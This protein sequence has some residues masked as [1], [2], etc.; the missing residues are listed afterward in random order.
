MLCF[1]TTSLLP[2]FLWIASL[3]DLLLWLSACRNVIMHPSFG[4]AL[5]LDGSVS[6][7]PTRVWLWLCSSPA[8]L[9]TCGTPEHHTLRTPTTDLLSSSTRSA[10]AAWPSTPC[11][12]EQMSKARTGSVCCRSGV[13][14]GM[15][16]R[17]QCSGFEA[18][19]IKWDLWEEDLLACFR[20]SSILKALKMLL[21]DWSAG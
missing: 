6:G 15:S 3:V 8:P 19:H 21:Q 1:S 20:E 18:G 11:S 13:Y 14:A 4:L 9:E 12:C 2:A 5:R 7:S 16:V 10:T 17:L